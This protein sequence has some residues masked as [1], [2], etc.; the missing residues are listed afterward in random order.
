MCFASKYITKMY[1]SQNP[2]EIPIIK[3]LD[4][5]EV[6]ITPQESRARAV[7]RLIQSTVPLLRGRTGLNPAALS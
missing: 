3:M 6:E 5:K 1:Q 2:Q 4:V 7:R